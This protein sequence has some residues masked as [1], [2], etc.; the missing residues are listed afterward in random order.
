MTASCS[1]RS[2]N[3]L[4]CA[5]GASSNTADF[6]I[7]SIGPAVARPGPDRRLCRQRAQRHAGSLS[8]R[9]TGLLQILTSSFRDGPKDQSSDVQMRVGVISGFRVH[10]CAAPRNDA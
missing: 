10:R 9:I 7:R 4:R 6:S 1:S 5:A 2:R 8:H 3:S